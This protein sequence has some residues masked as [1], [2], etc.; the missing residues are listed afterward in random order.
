[1]SKK[2]EQAASLRGSTMG[3][4]KPELASSKTQIAPFATSE[5]GTMRCQCCKRDRAC[6]YYCFGYYCTPCIRWNEEM[7]SDDYED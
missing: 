6:S 1:M 7:L 2:R 5:A 3:R 4:G